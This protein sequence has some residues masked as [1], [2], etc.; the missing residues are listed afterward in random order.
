MAKVPASR[1]QL[2]RAVRRHREVGRTPSPTDSHLLL[3]IYAAE[4]GLKALLLKS[5]GLHSTSRLEDEDLG[6]DLDALLLLLGARDRFG[7]IHDAEGDH[8]IPP[9]PFTSSSGTGCR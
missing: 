4:C 8:S 2:S 6:H 9:G 7:M 1:T 3:R 5:R